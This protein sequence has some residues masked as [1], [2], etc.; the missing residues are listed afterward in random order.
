[1]RVVVVGL[2]FGAEPAYPELAGRAPFADDVTAADWTATGIAAHE[3][4]LRG[5]QRVAGPDFD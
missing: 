3:S 2:E 5:G 4:A 1:M